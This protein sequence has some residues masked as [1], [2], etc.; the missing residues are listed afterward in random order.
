MDPRPTPLKPKF[1]DSFDNPDLFFDQNQHVDICETL[2][3]P[4]RNTNLRNNPLWQQEDYPVHST[5]LVSQ[6]L[7]HQL[8][9]C[10]VG[11]FDPIH[12]PS[13]STDN[14]PLDFFFGVPH[15]KWYMQTNYPVIANY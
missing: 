8:T 2:V 6:F 3:L 12:R 5:I 1:R 15:N 4:F 7:D 11:R 14:T 13:K 10:W 9:K